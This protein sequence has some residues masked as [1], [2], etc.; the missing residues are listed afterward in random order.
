MSS[1]VSTVAIAGMTGKLGS[2]IANALLAY[3]NTHIRGFCRDS[4]KLPPS[5]SSSP[6][7]SITQGS[8]S[9]MAAA[10]GFVKGSDVVICAYL[11]SN[12]FMVESQKVLIDAAEAEGVPRYIASD[13]ALD[14]TKLKLGDLPAK[15]PMIEI[16]GYLD[17]KKGIKGVHVLNGGFMDL[18]EMA[19]GQEEVGYWGSG[20]E[21]WDVTSYEDSAGFTA[22]V[23][24][25]PDATGVIKGLSFTTALFWSK[26]L[27]HCKV[28]GDRVSF[29]DAAK[30]FAKV[31]GKAPNLKQLGTQEE[32]RQMVDAA[33][34]KGETGWASMM[35]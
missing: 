5:L 32:L 7:V 14:Y 24:M 18:F 16:K 3:P 6:R 2:L 33:R 19:F 4:S 20:E 11:G 17:T 25:D 9:D 28:L 27:I 35:L 12:G 10:R 34:E 23:A 8:A 29:K 13:W 15:D 22:A 26:R 21:K 30:V 1:P 31:S